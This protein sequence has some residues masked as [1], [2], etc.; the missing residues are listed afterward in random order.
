MAELALFLDVKNELDQ[1]YASQASWD[2]GSLVVTVSP[3]PDEGLA[4]RKA[5]FSS[6]KDK[7]DASTYERVKAQ[8]DKLLC[9]VFEGYGNLTKRVTIRRSDK[10]SGELF[11]EFRA[12]LDPE[13]L[14]R[15]R[16]GEFA[17]G[18]RSAYMTVAEF[19][20]SEVWYLEPFLKGKF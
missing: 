9:G 3:Y 7:F 19:S 18:Y 20:G 12:I 15:I 10:T 13:N 4:L 6:L 14:P 2:G 16:N 8:F 1:R 17:G 5:L 11:V